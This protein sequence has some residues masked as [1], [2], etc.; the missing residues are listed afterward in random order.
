M[1]IKYKK[2]ASGYNY[3]RS[4]F[5]LLLVILI[6]AFI[7][8]YYENQYN[9]F[10]AEYRKQGTTI[11]DENWVA[12]GSIY[13]RLTEEV[14]YFPVDAV[15]TQYSYTD[16]FGAARSYGGE[17][18]HQGIDIMDNQN[19]RGRLQVISMT[20]GRITNI[21]WNQLGGWRVGITAPSGAYYYYAHL[22]DYEPGL[23]L[24]QQVYAGQLLGTMGDSGYGE[25]G[26]IGQFDVHLHI[27]ISYADENGEEAWINPYTLLTYI[28][29]L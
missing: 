22:Y 7:A 16:T 15:D 6:Y 13:E 20:E 24:G 28:E 27:G 11:I 17:R 12:M 21:G 4:S 8:L 3:A 18:L 9:E 26:T 29:N 23:E 10:V 1:R 25:E 2:K 19:E 5:L 14:L